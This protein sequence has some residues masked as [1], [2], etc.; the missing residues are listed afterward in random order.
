M[1]EVHPTLQFSEAGYFPGSR[2]PLET[3]I[4]QAVLEPKWQAQE[5]SARYYNPP[6]FKIHI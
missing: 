2:I 6:T 1:R 3:I 5:V 4:V